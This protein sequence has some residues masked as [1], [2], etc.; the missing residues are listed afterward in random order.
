VVRWPEVPVKPESPSSRSVE[1]PGEGQADETPNFLA[2]RPVRTVDDLVLSADVMARLDQ[3]VRQLDYHTLLYEDW[4]LR[5]IDPHRTGTALNFY[6]ASGTGKSLAAEAIA[7]RRGQLFI[8]VN[9]AEIESKYVGDTSKHIVACFASAQEQQAVLVFNEADSIL[10][11]RLSSVTQSADHSVNTSRAV[12]LSQ[13]DSFT[14]LVIFT[15]NFPR[16]YDAAFVRRILFHVRFDLPDQPTRLR[17]WQKLIPDEIPRL[18]PVDLDELAAR[19]AGLAGGDIVNVV[20][21]A[22]AG[23]VGRSEDERYLR[24]SDLDAEIDAIHRARA[25]VGKSPS[26]PAV[27]SVDELDE[28]PA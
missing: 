8:D 14:G 10:G 3:A 23:V 19:S 25:E 13:L 5:K 15:T 9:Y 22:A 7:S 18:E 2:R 17:L 4:N 26:G 11:S 12:M 21:A 24:T 16:N 6:G 20:L 28:V 1:P 27:V